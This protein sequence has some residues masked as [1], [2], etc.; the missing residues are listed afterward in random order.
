MTQPVYVIGDLHGQV[1]EL[2]RALSLIQGDGGPDAQ[3]VF[4][5]DYVD[6]GPDSRGLVERL[7]LGRMGMAR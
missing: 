6:R 3:I 7:M 4:L 1:A 5:G 2:E